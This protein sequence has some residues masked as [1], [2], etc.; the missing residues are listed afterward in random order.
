MSDGENAAPA[1][2]AA[3]APAPEAAPEAAPAQE[4]RA[5]LI[6][7][8]LSTT[9]ATEA[10][11]TVE[12]PASPEP[13]VA[14]EPAAEKPKLPEPRRAKPKS[15]R[16]RLFAKQAAQE[17]AQRAAPL[18]EKLQQ[19]QRE[20][21][22]TRSQFETRQ[23][24]AQ[25]ALESGDHDKA[26]QLTLGITAEQFDRTRLEQRGKFS[27]VDPKVQAKL[28]RL[29]QFE[30]QEQSRRAQLEQQQREYEQQQQL[31]EF[32]SEI[33]GELKASEIDG[34]DKLAEV[35]GFTSGLT[36]ALLHDQELTL[37]QAAANLLDEYQVFY[38]HLAPVASQFGWA[39][40]SPPPQDAN[41]G[42]NPGQPRRPPVS[43]PQTGAAEASAGTP[44]PVDETS[45]QRRARVIGQ[46][47]AL[48]RKQ[49]G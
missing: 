2:E 33:V 34:L 31:S 20:L 42:A 28:D 46:A 12:A 19:M 37:D 1:P 10:E 17:A 23:R 41:V 45:E 38:R 22:E 24:D 13:D 27:P 16:E 44:A 30:Q 32:E 4:N 40:P 6:Q 25:T 21:G 5:D 7:R 15:M 26:L 11:E 43:L 14:A 8:V 36:Q 18:E 9:Q 39:S 49:T 3:P 47:L 35:P 48:H 29:E